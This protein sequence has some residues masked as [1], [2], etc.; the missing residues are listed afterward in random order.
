MPLRNEYALSSTKGT[1]T[2]MASFFK[3]ATRNGYGEAGEAV[4]T[5]DTAGAEERD[6]KGPPEALRHFSN[7][8]SVERISQDFSSRKEQ[9][10]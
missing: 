3:V 2:M 7:S 8:E 10:A 1:A 6:S 4:V 9:R 5:V